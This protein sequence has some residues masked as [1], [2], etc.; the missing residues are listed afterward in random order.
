MPRPVSPAAMTFRFVADLFSGESGVSR[1]IRSKGFKARTW[2]LK[3]GP[4]F[5]LTNDLVKARVLKDIIRHRVIACMLAP[6]CTTFST[7]RDRTSVI[8]NRTFPWGLPNLKPT[9]HAKV[10]EG[11]AT[12]RTAIAVLNACIKTGTP[13]IMENPATSKCW[14]TP[15]LEAIA[16]HDCAASVTT[17]QC[18]FGQ[19]WRKRTRFL[20]VNIDPFDQQRLVRKCLGKDGFCSRTREKHFTLSGGQHASRAAAFPRDLCNEL[21]EV[22]L[23]A[24]RASLYN[25]LSKSVCKVKP[26]AN[27]SWDCELGVR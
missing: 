10:Q 17:D 16:A 11:N 6:P 9:D 25:F 24:E 21:A 1:K 18:M 4:E 13:A 12:M 7:A 5:D 2:E 23:S 26:R 19:P 3:D 8:R 15:E 27:T 22:L 20:C 14:Y